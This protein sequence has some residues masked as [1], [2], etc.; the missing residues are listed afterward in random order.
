MLLSL[1]S[2]DVVIVTK[3]CLQSLD[4]YFD[5]LI[6]AEVLSSPGL[7]EQLAGRLARSN[8]PFRDI[9]VYFLLRPQ[10]IEEY[11]YARARFLLQ[12]AKTNQYMKNLPKS[13]TMQEIE[14]STVSLQLLK[15]TLLW[16]S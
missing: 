15:D 1:V 13:V 2:E 10:S 14:D 7:L 5:T 9:N 3:V 8:S 12:T 4:F 11:F 6:I 16:K